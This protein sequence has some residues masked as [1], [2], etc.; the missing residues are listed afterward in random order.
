[1]MVIKNAPNV[2]LFIKVIQKWRIKQT[3]MLL[4]WNLEMRKC[5][6]QKAITWFPKITEWHEQISVETGGKFVSKLC[7]CKK[8]IHKQRFEIHKQRFEIH[9]QKRE[10][11]KRIFGWQIQN[12]F[13]NAW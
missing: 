3:I 4:P 6:H 11:H 10:I 12:G 8:T 13:T 1:M 9:K 5:R 7:V 2:P